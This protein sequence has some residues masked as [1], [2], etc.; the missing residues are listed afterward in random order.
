VPSNDLFMVYFSGPATLA[1]A[2]RVLADRKLHVVESSP[3][4]LSV[5]WKAGTGP[6]FWIGLNSEPWVVLEAAEKAADEDLPGLAALDRRFE[7]PMDD[8]DAALSDYNTLFEIQTTLQ[9]LTGG[10]V[11]MSWNGNVLTPEE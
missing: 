10:Y 2:A 9:E 3:G 7:V 11:V 4:T 5:R 1:D 6:V 8:L